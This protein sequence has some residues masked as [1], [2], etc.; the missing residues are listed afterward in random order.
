MV[1]AEYKH[2]GTIVVW[3]NKIAMFS[4]KKD[5]VALVVESDVLAEMQRNMI[6]VIWDLAAKK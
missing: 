1:P 5:L 2:N 6:K 3:A 4:L